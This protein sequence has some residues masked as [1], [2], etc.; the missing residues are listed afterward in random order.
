MVSIVVIGV[1]LDNARSARLE[2]HLFRA[3]QG[4]MGYFQFASATVRLAARNE[5]VFTATRILRAKHI[6]PIT[7]GLKDYDVK[8]SKTFDLTI[9]EKLYDIGRGFFMTLQLRSQS[10]E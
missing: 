8:I 3:D 2:V 9:I 6:R 4:R 7:R 5:L 10:V 1:A